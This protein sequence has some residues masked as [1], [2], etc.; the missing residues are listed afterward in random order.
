MDG[1]PGKPVYARRSRPHPERDGATGQPTRRNGHLTVAVPV[2]R[3]SSGTH[4]ARHGAEIRR[5]GIESGRDPGP[6]S[7]DLSSPID[8][9]QNNM[10]RQRTHHTRSTCDL[11]D[12]FPERLKRFREASGLTWAEL[13]RRL[14]THPQALR[15]WRDEAVRPNGRSG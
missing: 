14:G 12:D 8:I 3:A 4:R 1:P 11:L 10:P 9:R 7:A 2:P 15:R 6:A 5:G 13:S